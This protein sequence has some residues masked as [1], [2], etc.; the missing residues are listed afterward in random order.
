MRAQICVGDMRV[1]RLQVKGR[2][3]YLSQNIGPA[4]AGSAGP[5][6]PALGEPEPSKA[7]QHS[8]FANRKTSPVL[9]PGY[10]IQFGGGGGGHS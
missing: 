7:E 10:S 4:I 3:H 2:Q 8:Q 9:L 1:F 6:P 5:V